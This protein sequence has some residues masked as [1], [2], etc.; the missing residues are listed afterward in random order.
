METSMATRKTPTTVTARFRRARAESPLTAPHTQRTRKILKSACQPPKV[1]PIVNPA[2]QPKPRRQ[3]AA[4]AKAVQPQSTAA[5]GARRKSTDPAG[6][7]QSP[8]RGQRRQAR[9]AEEQQQQ[10]ARQR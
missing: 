3:Q 1:P 5:T 4:R 9:Q 6:T 2:D 10:K 7:S 8:S